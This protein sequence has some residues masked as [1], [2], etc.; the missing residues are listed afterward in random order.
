[1]LLKLDWLET[2]LNAAVREEEKREYDI[3]H[4]RAGRADVAGGYNT[5]AERDASPHD[6][7][8]R[9]YGTDGEGAAKGAAKGWARIKKADKDDMRHVL[10]NLARTEEQARKHGILTEKEVIHNYSIV[11]EQS[12]ES[13][14]TQNEKLGLNKIC[15]R[16]LEHVMGSLI[17]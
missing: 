10:K 2:G 17:L 16:T 4:R 5:S 9:A 3:E 8:D 6:P 12:L 11:K 7:S 15:W 14:M 1:M 13:Q